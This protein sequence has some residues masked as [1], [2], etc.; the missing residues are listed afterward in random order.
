M[1][2]YTPK[3]DAE[4][5]AVPKDGEGDGAEPKEDMEGQT[6]LLSNTVFPGGPPKAGDVCKF[7]V[8]H[9]YGD[10]SEV[11]YVKE[12]AKPGGARAAMHS[13][14]SQYAGPMGGGGD[15]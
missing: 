4:P 12:D 3:D 11:R 15:E 14:M 1:S 2:Y 10:E 7:E 13:R 8:V 6:S 5:E 9:V